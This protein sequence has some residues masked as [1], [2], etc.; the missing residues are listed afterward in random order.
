M[1]SFKFAKLTSRQRKY[2]RLGETLEDVLHH[3]LFYKLF[4]QKHN[5]KGGLVLS[6][7]LI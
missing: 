7:A 6:I 1:R 2:L 3:H 5:E 4:Q